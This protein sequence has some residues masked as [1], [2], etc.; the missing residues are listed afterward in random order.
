M[1]NAEK[2]KPGPTTLRKIQFHEVDPWNP[3][4]KWPWWYRPYR[5]IRRLLQRALVALGRTE[6]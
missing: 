1:N 4:F 5:N 6:V 2:Y 3:P